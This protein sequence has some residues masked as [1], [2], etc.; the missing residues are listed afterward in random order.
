METKKN[1]YCSMCL[2]N[3]GFGPQPQ[4]DDFILQRYLDSYMNHVIRIRLKRNPD[5]GF[6]LKHA[7]PCMQVTTAREQH[8]IITVSAVVLNPMGILPSG[9]LLV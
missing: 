7:P 3:L 9:C 6:I 4:A 5:L 2:Q 1:T 8:S